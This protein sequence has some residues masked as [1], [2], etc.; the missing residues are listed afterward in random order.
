MKS[1]ETALSSLFRQTER[2]N[3]KG[4]ALF[5]DNKR[6]DWGGKNGALLTPAGQKA[7]C[8]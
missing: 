3:I 5:D 8:R 6:P 2:G 1:T 7:F 4:H